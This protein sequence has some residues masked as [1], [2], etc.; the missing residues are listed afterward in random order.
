MSGRGMAGAMLALVLAACGGDAAPSGQ[1]SGPITV[2]SGRSESLVGDLVQQFETATGVDVEVRYGDTAELA[3]LIAEEGARS[4]AD[5]FWAQDAGALGALQTKKLFTTLPG[6]IV[7]RVSEAYRSTEGKWVGA[8]GRVRVVAYNPGL[9]AKAE[10]PGSV[11]GLTAAKWKGKVGW[12]PTNGS[13]QAF[14][15]A[16]R[17]LRGTDEARAWLAAMKANDAKAFATNDAIAEAIGEGEI[18]LGLVNHYYPFEIKAEQPEATIENHFL[19]AGDV[20]G[21]VNV[22]GAGVI[23][24]TKRRANAERF[25]DYLLS[26]DAQRYFVTKTWEYPLVSG[27]DADPRLP[28]LSSLQ[29]PAVDLSKLHDL[30]GTLALLR[31]VGLL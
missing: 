24:S 11:T 7:D 10:L 29:P 5:V 28:K 2:Y 13:F 3:A 14:V 19:S 23:V 20:G 1:A 6:S 15:T 30:E 8:S 22:S 17:L 26:A 9:V 16:F 18:P 21:L 4:P 27:I 31:E 25:V 12:A